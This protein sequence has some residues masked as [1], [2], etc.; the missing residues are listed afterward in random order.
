MQPIKKSDVILFLSD[1]PDWIVLSLYSLTINTPENLL[2][3][4]I[5]VNNANTNVNDEMLT[6]LKNKYKNIVR[7]I[8]TFNN[9]LKFNDIEAL[10][11]S[12]YILILNS[13]CIISSNLILKLMNHFDIDEQIK[14][15]SPVSNEINQ[16]PLFKG[17]SYSQMNQLLER[18]FL[19]KSLPVKEHNSRCFMI[20]KEDF[21]QM[22][23][24]ESLVQDKFF[25]K[26][27]S[28]DTTSFMAL[29]SYI[30]END[31]KKNPSR[32]INKY[33]QPRDVMLYYK[34]NITAIDKL[35]NIDTLFYVPTVVQNSGG[36]HVLFDMVNYLVIN[37]LNCNVVYDSFSNYKEIVLFRPIDIN[38][39]SNVKVGQIVSTIWS[40]TFK[41]K[42]IAEDKKIPLISFV[43]G[44][45]EYF[46]NGSNYGLI[47]I[48]HRIPDHILTISNYLQSKLKTVFHVDS[49]VIK[50]GIHYDLLSHH[51]N[52]NEVKTI[53]IILRNNVMKGD[54]LLLDLI[55][56]IGEKYHNLEVNVIC[57]QDSIVFP[58]LKNKDIILNKI[59]GPL[60]RLEI[61]SI[62]KYTDIFI[63]ASI[64]EGFGLMPLEAMA[65]GA[66]PIVSNSFG[67]LEY[68]E[69]GNNGYVI[70]EVNDVDKYV[71]KLDVLLQNSSLF[72]SMKKQA[73][74]TAKNFDYDA[75]VEGYIDY[76]SKIKTIKDGTLDTEDKQLVFPLIYNNENGKMRKVLYSLAKRM[77]K[78]M[79]KKIKKI[80]TMLYKIYN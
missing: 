6:N 77:P 19:L 60:S 16:L 34:K 9:N 73:A 42:K 22:L 78:R 32:K 49:R 64:N 31:E 69:D 80:V 50:N 46:D 59:E 62:L 30:F 36:C 57:I 70:N 40:S 27:E 63:D 15:I 13:N 72:Q 68:M 10:L 66:V 76:F 67:V 53:T 52:Q 12:D 8:N 56:I 79:K 38:H 11:T 45:E 2:G 65:A 23:L 7:V 26:T 21:N 33:N 51:S 54:F 20:K 18:K 58:L 48:T 5:V 14:C 39:I 55:K 47:E 41:A 4:I 28:N 35:I 37:G 29:D 1:A 24:N 74:A 25:V 17:F 71:E 44:Y 61:G 43:Q 75:V 3:N